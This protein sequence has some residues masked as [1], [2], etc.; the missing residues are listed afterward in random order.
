M[1]PSNEHCSCS[2]IFSF[3]SLTFALSPSNSS[4]YFLSTILTGYVDTSFGHVLKIKGFIFH[5]ALN[6]IST[7]SDYFSLLVMVLLNGPI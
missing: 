4:I 7:Y 2:I 1:I 3:K 5:L 6:T